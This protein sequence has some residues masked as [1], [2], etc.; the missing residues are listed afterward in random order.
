MVDVND[1][2]RKKYNL[3]PYTPEARDEL[4]T[5]NEEAKNPWL[6]GL[7]GFGAGISGG[8]VGQAIGQAFQ[9]QQA[10][11]TNALKAFDQNRNNAMQG[12]QFDRDL[13]KAE[14]EDSDYAKSQ[15]K[16]ARE[17][18]PNSAES[19]LA[20][21]LAAKMIPGRKFDGMNAQQIN[22]LLP[23]L[24]KIYEVEQ[25]RLEARDKAKETA[26][27]NAESQEER[28]LHWAELNQ[29]KDERL[30]QRQSENDN[31]D[32]Q[33]LSD[34][35]GNAQE[36]L[37]SLDNI[38]AKL[39][40][41]LDDADV[42][43]GTIKVK[44]EVKDLPGVSIPGYGR[45]TFAQEDAQQLE[46]AISRVFNTVLKDRSG[47]AVTSNEMQR[48]KEEFGRGKWNTEAQLIQGLK[49]YKKA[50]AAELKNR[51]AGFSP[52][53]VKTYHERGG[54]TS[55]DIGKSSGAKLVRV[56]DPKGKPRMVPEDQ[57]QA[58]LDNGGKLA[59]KA[60]AGGQ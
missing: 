6:A 4:V 43:D 57:V 47:A 5:A 26:Q 28:K 27:R 33:K 21:D 37:G 24:T 53:V 31:K 40:F 41:A 48:L 2:I 3:D 10:D 46:S 29:Q 44:G 13:T 25:K 23:S 59:D 9:T 38:E 50:V 19:G 49:D 22:G 42:K 12:F 7:A 55:A 39:G 54:I 15:D 18:D 52:D 58:A 17:S 8:N 11:T 30:A 36:F 20:R 35:L 1:Y 16:L 60:W 34:K 45:A 56:I 14:H 32:V 51:E